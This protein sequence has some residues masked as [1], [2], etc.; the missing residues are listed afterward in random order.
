MCGVSRTLSPGRLSRCRPA[1]QSSWSRPRG[2]LPA[3]GGH[4]NEGRIESSH[5]FHSRA[6]RYGHS[7]GGDVRRTATPDGRVSGRAAISGSTLY[8]LPVNAGADA[9]CPRDRQSTFAPEGRH[10]P[11]HGLAPTPGIGRSSRAP[12]SGTGFA[13]QGRVASPVAVEFTHAAVSARVPG[14][15]HG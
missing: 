12:T 9:E 14:V 1:P 7:R 2:H 15:C 11:G 4:F 13:Q 3:T 5:A 10:P 8:Q 6:V